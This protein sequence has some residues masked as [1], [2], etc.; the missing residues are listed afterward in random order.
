MGKTKYSIVMPVYLRDQEHKAVVINTLKNIIKVSRDYELIIADDGSPLNT[1]FLSDFTDKVIR[2]KNRG[3]SS[4][5]N[6][7]KNQAT[8]LFVA[9]V[10]D[11]IEVPHF[12]LEELSRGFEDKKAGVTAPI[13]GNPNLTPKRLVSGSTYY[14]HKFYPGYCFMLKK[15]R[16]FEDF[17]EQFTTNAGDVDYWHR[18]KER[19]LE[20]VRVPIEIWHKEGDVLHKMGYEELSK[21]SLDKFVKKWG[22][23]PQ[24]EY[25]S[26]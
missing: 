10:N 12:W 1:E 16:F 14:N 26:V 23:N 19:G 17:D 20:L 21:N 5:W 24:S 9:I 8:A 15:D 7:G 6:T 22:F 13:A 18:V 25:Y 11:D 2:Q 3:I 4:A